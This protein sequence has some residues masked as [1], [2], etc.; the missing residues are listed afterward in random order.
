M[1]SCTKAGPCSTTS[2]VYRT[3]RRQP[4]TSSRIAS[5]PRPRAGGSG[6]QLGNARSKLRRPPQRAELSAGPFWGNDLVVDSSLAERVPSGEKTQGLDD[7]VGGS[8]GDPEPTHDD[9]RRG[10]RQLSRT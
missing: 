10:A 7:L 2:S 5:R 8:Y 4:S 1:A 3:L 6:R 9:A